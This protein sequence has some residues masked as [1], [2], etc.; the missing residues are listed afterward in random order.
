MSDSNWIPTPG[1]GAI[2]LAKLQLALPSRMRLQQLVEFGGPVR[3]LLALY[4]VRLGM[5]HETTLRFDTGESIA[6]NKKSLDQQLL[7]DPRIWRARVSRL[8]RVATLVESPGYVGARLDPRDFP[9]AGHAKS[10]RP[11]EVGFWYETEAEWVNCVDSL[12]V[13]FLRRG[14]RGP[15]S[16]GYLNV[17]GRDVV[18]IGANIGDSALYFAARG[19]KHVYAFEPFTQTFHQAKRNIERSPFAERIT[20]LNEGCGDRHRIVRMDPT[21]DGSLW[22]AVRGADGEMGI[23]V[24]TL[25]EIVDRFGL[26]DDVL[27]SNCEGCEYPLLLSTSPKTRQAF[28]E[29]GLEYHFGCTELVRLLRGDGFTTHHTSPVLFNNPYSP[30]PGVMLAGTVQA[31]RRPGVGGHPGSVR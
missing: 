11:L 12:T 30:Q 9:G 27:K 28:A 2:A 19:A 29:M 8:K 26:M 17:R 21:A 5:L 24:S 4:L 1:S 13:H 6:V 18:D 25:P 14:R 22:S 15:G 10:E 20:L 3:S 31:V 16:Y 7:S 23:Q